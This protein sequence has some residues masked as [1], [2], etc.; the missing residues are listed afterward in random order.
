LKTLFRLMFFIVYAVCYEDPFISISDIVFSI[1]FEG[2]L[3]IN[4][5]RMINQTVRILKRE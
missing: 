4:A 3:V 2:I 5:H 1:I